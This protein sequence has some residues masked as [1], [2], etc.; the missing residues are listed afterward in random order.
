MK[1]F[2][3]TLIS[4]WGSDTPEEVF[5]ALNDLLTWAKS[6][7]FQTT[8]EFVVPDTCLL[9]G[10]SSEY[11]TQVNNDNQT[12]VEELTKFFEERV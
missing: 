11:E 2:F 9:Y 8:L 6:K 1:Q 3:S 7:G 4:S 12:L 10:S 5:W